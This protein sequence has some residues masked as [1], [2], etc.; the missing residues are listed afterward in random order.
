MTVVYNINIT[1]GSGYT[2]VLESDDTLILEEEEVPKEK[3]RR[4][5]RKN[6]AKSYREI[7]RELKRQGKAYEGYRKVNGKYEKVK[8]PPVKEKPYCNKQI[9]SKSCKL[10]SQE[11]LKEIRSSVRCYSSTKTARNAF[12]RDNVKRYDVKE[13]KPS[14]KLR[15]RKSSFRYFLTLTEGSS[16][17][18]VEVCKP[19]FFSC[20]RF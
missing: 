7:N 3:K 11:N 4:K 19:T 5:R 20:N 10:F 18:K 8:C 15:D 2:F 17:R 13:R 12:I 14:K 6:G 16:Q 9:C 1:T